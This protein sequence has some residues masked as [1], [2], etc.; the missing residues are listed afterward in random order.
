MVSGGYLTAIP[1]QTLVMHLADLYEHSYPR[2]EHN[3]ELL[4]D[5]QREAYTLI[6]DHWDADR[7]VFTQPGANAGAPFRTVL[8]NLRGVYE[9]YAGALLEEV[10]VDVSDVRAEV[11]S[12][13]G[14]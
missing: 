13:V 1:D 11:E 4:D 6:G 12:Y 5:W 9:W 14:R 7:R 8:F 2:I 3:G 10:L